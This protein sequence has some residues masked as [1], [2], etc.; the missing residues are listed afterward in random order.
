MP[1]TPVVIGGNGYVGRHVCQVLT[2]NGIGFAVTT[3]GEARELKE[4]FPHA[5]IIGRFSLA[6]ATTFEMV[7]EF[8]SFIMLAS[9]SVP[10]TFADSLHD[11]TVHN[12]LPFIDFFEFIPEGSRVIYVSSGGA[13]YGDAGA[14]DGPIAETVASASISPYGLVKGFVEETLRYHARR[15]GIRFTILRPSNPIGPE[16]VLSGG[17]VRRRPQGVVTIFMRRML[18][19][20]PITVFGDGTSERDY[21]DVRDLARAIHDIHRLPDLDCDTVNVGMGEGTSLGDLI[22]RIGTVVGQ[23][24]GIDWQ[25]ARG[26]DVQRIVL[27]TSRLRA[28]TGWQPAIS[29]DQSI[30]DTWAWLRS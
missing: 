28:L 8:R 6:D 5:D 21:F 16:V 23:Q 19:G 2:E 25:P 27:D 7:S 1:S 11:E 12:L 18:A 15:R 3:R 10:S 13:V 24:A 20:E 9:A 4:A 22:E 14:H 17:E 26:F 30:R 29:L